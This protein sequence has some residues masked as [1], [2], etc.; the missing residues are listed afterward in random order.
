VFQSIPNRGKISASFL[1]HYFGPAL[2]DKLC[3]C[4]NYHL[5]SLDIVRLR[6][7]GCCLPPLLIR[8]LDSVCL[9]ESQSPSQRNSSLARVEVQRKEKTKTKRM[10]RKQGIHTAQNLI[11][12]EFQIYP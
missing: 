9:M 10:R 3:E 5:S 4:A 8:T 11:E 12:E 2:P 7:F 6:A 1:V